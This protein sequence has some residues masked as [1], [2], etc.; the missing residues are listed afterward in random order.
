MWYPVGFVLIILMYTG[1]TISLENNIGCSHYIYRH[2][3][4]LAM[5][6]VSGN[7]TFYS[8]L[9]PLHSVKSMKRG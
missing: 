9:S 7:Y 3:Y 1:S 2:V 4:L 6:T 8:R 5:I